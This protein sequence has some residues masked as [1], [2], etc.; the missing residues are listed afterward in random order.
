MNSS[1]RDQ[2]LAIFNAAVNAVKPSVL[3]PSW[4]NKESFEGYKNIYVA[5]A[6]KA[7]AAMAVE[8]EKI[9]GNKITDGF[10]AVKYNHSLPLQYIR[11]LEA[12][13]PLPDENSVR[14]A[15]EMIRLFQKASTDDLIIFLL[16]GGA[17]SLLTDV[18][19]GYTLEK[20]NAVFSE[21]LNSGANIHEINKVRKQLSRI[22]G[23]GLVKYANGARIIS[24]IISDVM[25]DDIS[26]IGSGPTDSD[27]SSVTNSI[28]GDNRTAL[29]AAAAK[30]AGFGYEVKVFENYLAGDAGEC[31]HRWI[32]KIIADNSR[33][34]CYIA[35]GE[36]TVNVTGK[37]LGGRNQHFALTAAELL[38]DRK[39]ITLLAAGTDGT[40]GPTDATGAI[41]DSDTWNDKA[42]AFLRNNDSYNF[43]KDINGLV[44]SGPTQTNVMDIVITI[45]AQ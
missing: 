39:N 2:L 32:K 17:S 43:L 44:V 42:P 16:S 45:C 10:I 12:A 23:G 29:Q 24:Y 37:G 21:L 28:I 22:K 36:T 38:R 13:H 18:P 5:G 31:A 40:D 34:C 19:E 7:A 30:A 11:Q 6:G 25:G 27:I 33:N 4:L 3:I 1:I 41:I 8:V 26:V 35:G 20:L 15:E 14:A 9:L